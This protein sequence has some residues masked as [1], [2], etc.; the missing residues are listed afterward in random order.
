MQETGGTRLHSIYI[1][2]EGCIPEI[3]GGLGFMVCSV[4]VYQETS[5]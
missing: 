1:V 2:H 3:I 5:I 4:A